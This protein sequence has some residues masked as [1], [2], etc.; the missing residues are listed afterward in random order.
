MG[1]MEID[2]LGVKEKVELLFSFEF[3]SDRKRMSVIIKHKGV[4]KLYTKGA[5]AIIK[6]RLAPN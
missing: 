4:I 2:V 5:D 3:N 1:M 6:E